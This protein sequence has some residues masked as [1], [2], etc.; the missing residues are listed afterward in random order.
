MYYI[1][2]FYEKINSLIDYEKIG[3]GYLYLG[4]T[5]Y[6]TVIRVKLFFYTNILQSAVV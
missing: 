4:P 5:D 2:D 6:Y 1:M 3:N